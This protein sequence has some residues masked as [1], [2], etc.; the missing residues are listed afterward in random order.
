MRHKFPFASA[1]EV[2]KTQRDRS[3][4]EL[5]IGKGAHIQGTFR[6]R[7]TARIDGYVEGAIEADGDIHLGK[8]AVIVA[9]IQ[10]EN[11]SA[12]APIR[13]DI[14]ARQLVELRAPATLEGSIHTMRFFI[15]EGVRVTG[16]LTMGETEFHASHDSSPP[17]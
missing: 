3:A 10:A 6:V 13:G 2:K 16:Q 14:V 5:Y 1:R 7:G 15:E 9:S 12:Q 4:I 17:L 8:D 11:L